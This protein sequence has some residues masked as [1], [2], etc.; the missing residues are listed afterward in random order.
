[1]VHPLAI[2]TRIIG[3][4]T[5]NCQ[6]GRQLLDNR[7]AGAAQRNGNA[8]FVLDE[9]IIV[10]DLEYRG[11]CQNE[12]NRRLSGD[13]IGGLCHL[14]SEGLEHICPGCPAEQTFLDGKVHRHVTTVVYGGRTL[15]FERVSSPRHDAAGRVVAGLKLVRDIAGLVESTEALRKA[16]EDL[17]RQNIELRALDHVKDGLVRDVSHELKTPVTADAEMLWPVASNLVNS[18]VKLSICRPRGRRA[19][20][21]RESR[22]GAG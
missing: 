22:P 3:T 10:Q 20:L 18:A 11:T 5:G 8:S 1:M 9:R 21:P 6:G 16:K 4:W 15:H 13:R 14:A 7:A 19:W 17:G 12:V 2:E